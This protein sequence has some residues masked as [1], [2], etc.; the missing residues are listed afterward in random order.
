[1][2]WKLIGRHVGVCFTTAMVQV[3]HEDGLANRSET[4]QSCAGSTGASP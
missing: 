4:W 3:F 2:P 1:M